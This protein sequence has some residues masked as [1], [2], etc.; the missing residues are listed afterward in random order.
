[1]NQHSKQETYH[2]FGKLPGDEA[3][4]NKK[5]LLADLSN[6]DSS[7]ET[8]FYPYYTRKIQPNDQVLYGFYRV[9][10]EG[11][12]EVDLVFRLGFHG[13]IQMDGYTANLLRCNAYGF[14]Q[15]G[16]ASGGMSKFFNTAKDRDIFAQGSAL[17][18]EMDDIVQVGR[19]DYVN[20]YTAEIAFPKFEFNGKYVS[21]ADTRYMIFGSDVMS[22]DADS[23][24]GEIEPSANCMTYCN[25]TRRQFTAIYI[26]YPDDNHLGQ[27]GYNA[28]NGGLVSN[29]FHCHIVGRW[30]EEQ[31]QL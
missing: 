15:M 10:D 8:V 7:R 16:Y 20:V 30:Q 31:I 4:V 28:L 14:N 5:V 21:F 26:T 1:M 25:K 23:D 22:Q 2:R 12:L 9:W 18:S 13:E 17:S 19:N 24:Y 29:S 3:E 27:A 6:V 11:T